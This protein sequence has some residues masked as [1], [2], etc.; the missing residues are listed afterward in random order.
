MPRHRNTVSPVAEDSAD[1]RR[2]ALETASWL[3][4]VRAYEECGRRYARM[5]DHFDLTISQFDVLLA[6]QQL[7]DEAMPKHI[8]QRL[9]VTRPNV[10]GLLRRL[11]ERQ[12]IQMVPHASDGRALICRL[13][14]AGSRRV[15]DARSAAERFVRAQTA[16]FP[17]RDLAAIQA[18]MRNMYQ[19]LQSL[20]PDRIAAG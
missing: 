4:V 3:A 9:L 16:P 1:A 10:T 7:A 20:D 19:H 5:L 12:L 17:D 15:R 18:L 6:V 13:T 8:A 2:A 11:E 14:P